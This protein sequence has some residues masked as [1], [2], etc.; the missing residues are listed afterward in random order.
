MSSQEDPTAPLELPKEQRSFWLDSAP[1]SQFPQLKENIDCD[2]AIVGGGIAGITVAYKLKQAG[3]SVAVLEKNTIASG[4]TAG[5][6]GKVTM[7][8]GLIYAELL[9]RF[10]DE[11]TRRYAALSRKAFDDIRSL[12]KE[13]NIA[14]DWHDADNFVYTADHKTTESLKWEVAV[15]AG[16]GLP[17]SYETNLTLPFETIGA[18][19][20]AGQAYFSAVKYVRALAGLI[21]GGGSYV[22]EHSQAAGIHEGMPCTVKAEGGKITAKNLIVATKVPAA[23]LIGRFTYAASEYPLTSYVVAGKYEGDLKDM[24][25]SPDK[26]HYSLLPVH[27]GKDKLLLVGGEN[28]VP[29]LKRSEPNHRKLADYA[30]RQFGIQE[31]TFRWKAMD[32]LA[33]DNLP[34]VG[35]LYPWSKQAYMIGGFKKW[36]LNLSIVAA[37]ILTQ[38]IVEGDR[39]NTELFA[40]HR[41][42]APAL[43]PKAAIEYFK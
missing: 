2:V 40:P 17:A 16:M 32:Y 42:S 38:A 13:K 10:G 18:V 33:Y 12:V 36:G 31:I 43:I 28:H 27:A 22:F 11:L 9:R 15:A 37:N 5:A 14:C 30:Q 25:I 39:R 21:D 20:F 24:Y 29:G 35:R 1:P 34:L 23:P 41:L 4:T 3:L 19:K 7:Q 8:H 26:S 6:T